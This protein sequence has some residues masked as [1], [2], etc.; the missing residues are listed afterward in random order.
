MVLSYKSNVMNKVLTFK[1]GPGPSKVPDV[2]LEI[3]FQ[4]LV[5]LITS[6]IN[7]YLQIDTIIIFNIASV[8]KIKGYFSF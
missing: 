3:I 5:I 7:V 1:I 4:L 2:M 8:T 6:L